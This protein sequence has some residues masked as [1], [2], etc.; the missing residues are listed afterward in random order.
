ME[1]DI[2][3]Y[4]YQL[5]C[6]VGHPVYAIYISVNKLHILL[7]RI[8][9]NIMFHV[10]RRSSVVR[11]LNASEFLMLNAYIVFFLNVTNIFLQ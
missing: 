9:L 7:K 10:S 5:S 1:E 8:T 4:L 11:I 3:N 6:F 2:L